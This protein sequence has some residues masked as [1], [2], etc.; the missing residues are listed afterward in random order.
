MCCARRERA[1]FAHDLPDHARPDAAAEHPVQRVVTGREARRFLREHVGQASRLDEERFGRDV[2]H[3][4]H[5]A[6]LYFALLREVR[7]AVDEEF[8]YV[9]DAS[10]AHGQ[11]C[12]AWTDDPGTLL[13]SPERGLLEVRKPRDLSERRFVRHRPFAPSIPVGIADVI[14][15]TQRVCAPD[16][17]GDEEQLLI[18][19]KE[20][21][22]IAMNSA[23]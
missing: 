21:S 5:I 3:D 14:S 9:C 13:T 15:S 10:C 23:R 22:G 8:N 11:A 1:P 16:R 7:G 4:L 12:G 18:Y 19:G 2:Q 6:Q 17:T 20:S